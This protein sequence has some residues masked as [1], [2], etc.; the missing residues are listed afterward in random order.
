MAHNWYARLAL[1]QVANNI[2][3][4]TMPISQRIL[5]VG[6]QVDEVLR[7]ITHIENMHDSLI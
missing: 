2:L 6:L 7:I 1:E 4:P 5:E 3:A